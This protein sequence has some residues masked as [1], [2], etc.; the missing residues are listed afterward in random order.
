MQLWLPRQN[1]RV[2]VPRRFMT[3]SFLML[4]C[5]HIYMYVMCVYIIIDARFSGACRIATLTEEKNAGK[6]DSGEAN[7]LARMWVVECAANLCL[8]QAA[9]QDVGISPQS[10]ALVVHP[11]MFT[12]DCHVTSQNPESSYMIDCGRTPQIIRF[13][14]MIKH[15]NY[16]L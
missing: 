4:Q 6:W 5:I 1:V 8:C 12:I 11:S 9:F 15:S 2:C 10:H 7:K 14:I 13:C 3:G 16:V